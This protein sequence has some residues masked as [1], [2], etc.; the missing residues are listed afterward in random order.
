[1]NAPNRT[2]VV[3]IGSKSTRL[4]GEVLSKSPNLPGIQA[5]VSVGL[6]ISILLEVAILP[7]YRVVKTTEGFPRA[8]PTRSSHWSQPRTQVRRPAGWP[9]F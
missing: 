7:D 3:G 6:G 5:A 4:L 9:R 1:M 8:L 2:R